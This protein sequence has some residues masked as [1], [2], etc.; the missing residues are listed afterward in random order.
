RD[1]V[2]PRP[3]ATVLLMRDTGADFE[4]LMTRRSA[5]ASFAPGA[6]VFPGGALDAADR[7]PRAQALARFR[8]SQ[9]GE[10][11]AFSIAALREAFEELGILLAYDSSG[12]LVTQETVDRLDRSD[13]AFFD[14]IE[15]ES[16]A[17]AGD[18]MHWYCHWVTDPDL[19]KRFDVRFLVA[20]IPEGQT[21]V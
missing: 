1:P 8:A 18:S 6:F 20:R 4:I 19:P 9:G 16:L 10:L 3:A 2:A 17:L 21:P 13:L 11:R 12:R 15:R 7:A 5:T 14:Q